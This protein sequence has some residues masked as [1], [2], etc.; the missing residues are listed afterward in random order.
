MSYS[1]SS[2]LSA[3]LGLLLLR[4]GLGIVFLMHG[5]QKLN[6]WTIAGTASNFQQMGVPSPELAATVAAYA[7]LI[8][9]IALIVGLLSRIAGLV[10]AVDMFG[11]IYFAHGSSGF[12]SAN[13]GYE[14]PL[15]LAL[16]SLA[17]FLLGPGRFAI[18]GG[19]EGRRGWG[20]FA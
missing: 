11:A 2:P 18:A 17:V 7:E 1:H 6:D 9:G 4:V 15:V 16:A 3:P 10:L 13:G 19:L 5:L 8:G 14:F 20:V 12:F